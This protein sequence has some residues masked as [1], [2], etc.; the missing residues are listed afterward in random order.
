MK[1]DDE[2][3]E[4]DGKGEKIT[5]VGDSYQL[6]QVS[7]ASDL[8]NLYI[9]K[10][11]KDGTEHFVIDSYGVVLCRAFPRIINYS[12]SRQL[13]G[14][15]ITLKQYLQ[16]WNKMRIALSKELRGL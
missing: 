6:K 13:K 15:A 16:I 7:P 1:E 10:K 9:K 8:W 2:E 14:Q 4:D 3:E 12:I 11:K 5:I